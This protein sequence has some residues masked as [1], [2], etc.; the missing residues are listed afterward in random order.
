MPRWSEL[1]ADGSGV[2]IA[3]PEP[4]QAPGTSRL[5]NPELREPRRHSPSPRHVCCH[6]GN[7][8]FALLLHSCAEGA[9]GCCNN[10]TKMT[11]SQDHDSPTP[12]CPPHTLTSAPLGRLTWDL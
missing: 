2:G 12:T 10:C 11:G 1:C 4:H 8:Q 5:L 9:G 7:H 3:R 6:H